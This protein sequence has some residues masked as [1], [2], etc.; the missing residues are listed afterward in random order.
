[1]VAPRNA[2]STGGIASAATRQSGEVILLTS[3]LI[4]ER[5]LQIR[6]LGA[7]DQLVTLVEALSPANRKP[8]DGRDDY[9]SKLAVCWRAP[10][11][12]CE[13]DLLRSGPRMPAL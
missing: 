6:D 12:S 9:L 7:D 13:I 3:D 2:P 10:R 5:Y 4:R 11:I 1:M 8:G